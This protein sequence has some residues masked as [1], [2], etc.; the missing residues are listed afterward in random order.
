MRHR[1]T[2]TIPKSRETII[3]EALTREQVLRERRISECRIEGELEDLFIPPPT[4]TFAEKE[5]LW[6][7]IKIIILKEAINLIKI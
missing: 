6:R 5:S 7:R 1:A 4:L 2:V 3:R